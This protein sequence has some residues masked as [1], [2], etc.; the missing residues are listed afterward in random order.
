[1]PYVTMKTIYA[2]PNGVARA[3]QA[4]EVDAKEAKDLTDKGYAS[5]ERPTK[6]EIEAADMRAKEKEKTKK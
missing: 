2:G 1:M 4:I 6:K 5:D 3:G